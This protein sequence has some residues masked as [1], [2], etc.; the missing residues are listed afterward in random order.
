MLTKEDK[1]FIIKIAR[2]QTKTDL[3]VKMIER[4]IGLLQKAIGSNSKELLEKAI[5]KIATPVDYTPI[6]ITPGAEIKIVFRNKDLSPAVKTSLTKAMA[7]A[8]STLMISVGVEMAEYKFTTKG[9][10]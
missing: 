4:K 10:T 6:E 3:K 7:E 5:N 1:N 2:A 9:R 8:I